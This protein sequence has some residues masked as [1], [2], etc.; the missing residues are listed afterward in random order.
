M[1]STNIRLLLPRITVNNE[2]N[3]KHVCCLNIM[4][5][6]CSEMINKQPL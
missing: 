1:T 3:T 5:I 6:L 2:I 4:S